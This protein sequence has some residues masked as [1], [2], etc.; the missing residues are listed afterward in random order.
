MQTILNSS[1]EVKYVQPKK[2][3]EFNIAKVIKHR[4]KTSN[5]LGILIRM[6]VQEI[7]NNIPY[8]R[9]DNMFHA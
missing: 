5:C 2:K 7:W 8:T 6:S 1:L 3:D 4:P 9:F